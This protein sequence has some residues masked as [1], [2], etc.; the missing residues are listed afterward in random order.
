LEPEGCTAATLAEPDDPEAVFALA[1]AA[2]KRD[3]T[4]AGHGHRLASLSVRLGEA[5]GLTS[6]D[7]RT[8]RCAGYLHDVGKVAVP[9]AILLKSGPLT[10]A[11]WR[12]MYRHTIHGEEI[13]RPL[14]GLEPVLPVIRHHHE[15]W[16][17]SGYPDG[18]RGEEIPLLARI[19]QVADIYDALTT[20]RSYKSGLDSNAAIAV[21]REEARLG[22]RDPAIVDAFAGLFSPRTASSGPEA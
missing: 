14:E 17:G 21:L 4:C 6:T 2:E 9:D 11:E 19:L 15:R 12:V 3:S 1:L 16:D 18:L 7:L 22:W 20:P 8:L 13:C 5:L 10:E